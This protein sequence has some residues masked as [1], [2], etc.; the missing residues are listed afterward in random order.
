[1]KGGLILDVVVIQ[2]TP[3]FKQLASKDQV[4]LVWG[5]ALLVLDLGPDIFDG[6]ISYH[7]KSDGL[8]SDGLDEDL[9][10]TTVAK[11][12]VKEGLF[13]DVVVTHGT[14][15]FKQYATIEQVLVV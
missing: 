10:T 7:F 4:L 12:Q 8:A 14:P 11:H 3:I 1:M 9:H 6:V 15:I 5:D 13:L 2:G